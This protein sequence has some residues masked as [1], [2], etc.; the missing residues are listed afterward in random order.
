M[1]QIRSGYMVTEI[2]R[3]SQILHGV[4]CAKSDPAT[5]LQKFF[6]HLRSFMGSHVP[7]L[8]RL[9]RD[10][11][12]SHQRRIMPTEQRWKLSLIALVS[13]ASCANLAGPFSA[14]SRVHR[15]LPHHGPASRHVR[16]GKKNTKMVYHGPCM[17]QPCGHSRVRNEG[18]LAH[19][20]PVN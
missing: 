17:L 8:I 14:G 18:P 12:S 7:N 20:L 1:C 16:N 19:R 6:D 5:W 9:H 10:R 15:G 11:N 4:A 13:T 3:S 2:L